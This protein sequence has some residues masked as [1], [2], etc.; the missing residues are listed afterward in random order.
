MTERVH[1]HHPSGDPGV[2]RPSQIGLA[3][4]VEPRGT[5]QRMRKVTPEVEKSIHSLASAEVEMPRSGEDMTST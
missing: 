3:D 5:T 2:D 4:C 1:M